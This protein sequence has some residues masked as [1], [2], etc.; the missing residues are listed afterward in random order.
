MLTNI[1][2]E[3]KN[4][5]QWV[6]WKYETIDGKQ[7]KI[8]Y[9]ATRKSKASV[10]KSDTWT[11]FNTALLAS[12]K[13]NY[14]GIGLVL[15]ADDPYTIIDLDNK[16]DKPCTPEQLARHQ[17]IYESFNSYTELST[18]GTGVHIIVKGKLPAGVHRDNVE[19]YSSER[20]MVCTG[21]ILRNIPIVDYQALL[22]V[23][24]GE[25]KPSETSDLIEQGQ[26]L[27]DIDIVNMASAASNGDKFD[28]LCQGNQTGYESQSEADFAL[29]SILAYYSRSDEQ[30]RRLF[31][32][33]K[34]GKREKAIRNNTYLDFALGKIRAQQ[35][36]PVD[37]TQ[38][39]FN[40]E[41]L[42]KPKPKQVIVS[43]QALD[44]PP[45]LVGELAEYF[46][47]T[48][49]RPVREIALA[50][51][52]AVVAGVS[53]RSYN[54][55]G[56]GLNQYLILLARTGSGKEGALSGIENLIAAIRPQLP[57]AD[58]FL[59]PAA[60]AS[61]QA[62]V[63]VLNDRPCFVSV[64]GEFGLTLQ[65]IS[66]RRAN[67]SQVM[68][69]KV[70]LDLYAKSGWNRMLRS[71]VYSDTEK[72]TAIVQSPNVSILG[73]STPETF[74]DGLDSSHIAEGLIPRFSIIEY[75][76]DRP[77]RNRNPNHPPSKDLAQKFADLITISLTTTNNNMVKQV[78]IDDHSLQLLDDFDIRA[79][80]IM[81]SAKMDVEMQVWNRAHLKALKL[82]A[83]L[84]VGINPHNPVVT[85]ELA[86]WAITFVVADV[87]L[88][89]ARF[90][91]GDVGTGDSKQLADLRRVVELYYKPDCAFAARTDIGRKLHAAKIIPYA[92]LIR[93]TAS[94]SSFKAD[95][96]GAT[97][98]LKRN[99]Q[100]M[101]DSGM[102]V[103]IAKPQLA[104]K[105]DYSGVAYGIG[106]GFTNN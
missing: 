91:E 43:K 60:F 54:I 85:A 49:I 25:M 12:Q 15:T 86:Q 89:V 103:E 51:A 30:V 4:L 61:G 58:Q 9:C 53:G 56:S 72:N 6:L 98:S 70:L 33:S 36:P 44:Y 95:K 8:P 19:V 23:L 79:D 76:G 71:S 77:P 32:M 100:V 52:L 28:A 31:R 55:S 27:E 14:D 57:M 26:S 65:Q 37:M 22:N 64:L 13:G 21:N 47:S 99:V 39:S 34:L 40:A 1:P 38:L 16:A 42:T 24:Y 83:L 2:A 35:P 11:D 46:Y 73:E 7:T 50:A 84:A 94:L 90:K 102:L 80:A 66:D 48:A 93:Q 45:G 69:R 20:Y 59:G 68:L 78:T 62:L 105:Y 18:S 5:H 29:L 75:T 10:T 106:R 92:Y 97:N 104:E 17:K 41:P 88:V 96:M 3:L 101:I 81:N 87:S 63:K 67:S 82:A 74:F